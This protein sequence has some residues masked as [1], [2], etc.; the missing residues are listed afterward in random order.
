M[1]N[2]W[3]RDRFSPSQ[4]IISGYPPVGKFPALPHP[5][6]WFLGKQSRHFDRELQ[7]LAEAENCDYLNLNLED[8][9]MSYMA[10]DGFHP[11]KVVYSIWGEMIAETIR[12]PGD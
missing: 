7:K 12:R 8:G 3:L 11:S 5:L 6:R 4:I 10:T 1:K 9:D 2:V